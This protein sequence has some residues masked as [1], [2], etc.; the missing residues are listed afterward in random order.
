M[1]IIQEILTM[2]KRGFEINSN[3]YYIRCIGRVK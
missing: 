2:N 1:Y 3:N